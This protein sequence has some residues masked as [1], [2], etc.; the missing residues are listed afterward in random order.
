PDG[1]FWDRGSIAGGTTIAFTAGR[2]FVPLSAGTNLIS[3]NG[4]TWVARGTGLT[5]L[6]GRISQRN[7]T[8]YARSGDYLATSS[9]GPNWTQYSASALPGDGGIAFDGGRY[10]TVRRVYGSGCCGFN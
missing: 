1:T 10:V 5:N 7:G 9:D 6:L 8:F 4:T 3:A 2:F